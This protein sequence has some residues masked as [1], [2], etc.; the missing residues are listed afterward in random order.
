MR[1]CE[2]VF[3]TWRESPSTRRLKW[4]HHTH[5]YTMRS[6]TAGGGSI[7][8]RNK[9]EQSNIYKDILKS[10]K[11]RRTTDSRNK[12]DP[13]REDN[14]LSNLLDTFKPYSHALFIVNSFWMNHI[15]YLTEHELTELALSIYCH[16]CSSCPANAHNLLLKSNEMKVPSHILKIFTVFEYV[17]RRLLT[18]EGAESHNKLLRQLKSLGDLHSSFLNLTECNVYELILDA[19]N[20]CLEQRFNKIFSMEIRFC[21]NQ[22][23]RLIVD[24]MNDN[25]YLAQH[26][27]V[28]D[29]YLGSLADC[30]GHKHGCVYFKMFLQEQL[31]DENYFFYKAVQE[32]KSVEINQRIEMGTVIIE[33]YVE[34]SGDRQ[35]NLS[36][37]TRKQI[38]NM[39]KVTSKMEAS[40]HDL[41]DDAIIKPL[42]KA[43]KKCNVSIVDMVHCVG[44]T[45][46]LF[47]KAHQEIFTLMQRNSWNEF[48]NKILYYCADD[49]FVRQQET[50]LSQRKEKEI[51]GRNLV[52]KLNRILRDEE[53]KQTLEK[54]NDHLRIK[55]QMDTLSTVNTQLQNEIASNLEQNKTELEVLQQK[56]STLR[57]EI[58]DLGRS[59][60][61]LEGVK[62]ERYKLQNENINLKRNLLQMDELKEENSQLYNNIRDIKNEDEAQISAL[63][64]EI[65]HWKGSAGHSANE[66]ERLQQN[67]GR[68]QDKVTKLKRN[69]ESLVQDKIALIV[70]ANMELDSLRNKI[71]IYNKGLND[72]IYRILHRRGDHQ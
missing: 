8:T 26:L 29:G 61:E 44:F 58:V 23:Y 4:R 59:V 9:Q 63:K 14:I 24:I 47:D 28:I 42:L 18:E 39:I 12:Q 31:Q 22:F 33:T 57:N 46:D 6:R 67:N 25:V 27:T 54:E 53:S 20:A 17:L 15:Q 37:S 34:Q 19:F 65:V 2:D 7:F 13:L 36:A 21:F 64:Q 51:K 5:Y 35:V 45:E 60:S 50:K 43:S 56:N 11:K 70:A 38:L 72:D 10:T 49:T 1:N 30:L 62:E 41:N 69:E 32:Y 52:T 66:V 55:T 68:L 40:D 71:K 3:S 16:L 48:R